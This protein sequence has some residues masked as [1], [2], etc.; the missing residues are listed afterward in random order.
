M[1]KDFSLNNV[2]STPSG[3]GSS[4]DHDDSNNTVPEEEKENGQVEENDDVDK[5]GFI[6]IQLSKSSIFKMYLFLSRR[7]AVSQQRTRWKVPV[8]KNNP[9]LE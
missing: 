6:S 9:H 8:R 5:K 2:D 1:E 4:D 3:A 7:F